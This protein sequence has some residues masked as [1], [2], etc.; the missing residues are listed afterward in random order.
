VVLTHT[1]KPS[2]AYSNVLLPFVVQILS[3]AEL[4]VTT[5][6]EWGSW[7]EKVSTTTYD[8]SG[9]Y[10]DARQRDFQGFRETI[11]TNPDA[12]IVHNRFLIQDE[13]LKGR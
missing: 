7:E 9:G 12:T 10:Y 13:F 2:T 5:L 6:G 1:Y 3:Q 11:Q 8:Y 4:T